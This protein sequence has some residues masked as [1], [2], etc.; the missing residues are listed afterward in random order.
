MLQEHF[1]CTLRVS[2]LYPLPFD[3]DDLPYPEEGTIYSGFAS[4]DAPTAIKNISSKQIIAFKKLG[5]NN[6]R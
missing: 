1:L 3:F 6:I 5:K 2:V 4:Q